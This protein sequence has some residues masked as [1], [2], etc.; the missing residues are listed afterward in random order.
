[1]KQMTAIQKDWIA[2]VTV[3]AQHKRKGEIRRVLVGTIPKSNLI[4]E[5]VFLVL[6]FHQ[7][8]WSRERRSFELYLQSDEVGLNYR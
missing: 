3:H 1:M 8:V 2:G 5:K 6:A 7:K 4:M